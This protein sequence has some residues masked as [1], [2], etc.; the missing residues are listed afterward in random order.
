MELAEVALVYPSLMEALI[1]HDGIGLVVG[2]EGQEVVIASRT[3]TIWIGPLGQRLKGQNPLAPWSDT[4][5]A[6][7]QL[8]RVAR[9]PNA[10]DVILLGAWD[11]NKVVSFEE[12]VAS[13]GGLGG[14][15]DWPFLAY[16]PEERMAARSIQGSEEVYTRLVAI[17]GG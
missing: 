17:Y 16:P 14:P 5:W 7:E 15:Q 6:A 11:G 10:G 1:D 9:F 2:R 3:G 13:H 4:E 8:A 12:Q